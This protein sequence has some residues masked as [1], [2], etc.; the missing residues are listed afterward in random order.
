MPVR[1]RP[2][3]HPPARP[4]GLLPGGRG[5]HHPSQ[6]GVALRRALG[7]RGERVRGGGDVQEPRQGRKEYK[8]TLMGDPTSL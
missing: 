4:G 3:P 7:A 1:P 5:R 6:A 8:K 2:A